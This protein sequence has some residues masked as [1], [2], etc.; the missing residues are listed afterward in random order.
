LKVLKIIA[1]GLLA[2]LPVYTYVP[3]L[4]AAKVPRHTHDLRFP[5]KK[6]KFNQKKVGPDTELYGKVIRVGQIKKGS[7]SMFGT[8]PYM[9]NVDVKLLSKPK[10][11][12]LST[13][14]QPCTSKA[15]SRKVSK[16]K[17]GDTVRVKLDVTNTCSARGKGGAPTPPHNA[18]RGNPVIKITP[19]NTLLVRG[20]AYIS[21]SKVGVHFAH[22]AFDW[23]HF[24]RT[25]YPQYGNNL[26]PNCHHHVF[27]K[28]AKSNAGF[29]VVYK[30]NP[31]IVH[32]NRAPRIEYF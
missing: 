24:S 2:S 12:K 3:E 13:K 25:R 8:T 11:A 20:R 1:L 32:L 28:V 29:F 19:G 4:N 6:V 27:K 17:K 16:L 22:Q 21:A 7:F 31:G 9:I 14:L 23:N 5:N 15:I 10:I 18:K 30:K 26:A